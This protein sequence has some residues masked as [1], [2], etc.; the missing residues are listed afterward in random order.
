[1]GVLAN[2]VVNVLPYI[3]FI[4]FVVGVIY[5][6]AVWWSRPSPIPIAVFPG[7]RSVG[8]AI[9]RVLSD[10]IFF[11]SL[12]QFQGN[13]ILWLGAWLF[14]ISF[15][16]ILLRHLR[17]FLG[18]EAVPGWVAAVQGIGIA[19]ALVISIPLL[20]L[21]LRRI[22]HADI[23]WISTPADYFVLLLILSVVLSGL[24][25][26]YFARPFVI[27]VK[28]VI[29]SLMALKPVDLSTVTLNTAFLVHFF[30]VQVLAMYIPFS[31]VMH[32]G[33]IFFSPTRTHHFGGEAHTKQ[34]EE[35]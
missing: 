11:R 1:M 17:Y 29:R 14:H 7:Q 8:S 32:F 22:V 9:V 3:T 16:L 21:L 12:L 13:R 18:A 5:R 2:F 20:Y 19:A 6:I 26:K 35:A 15:G 25:A 23:K 33:G 34:L 27:D 10:V 28:Y 24:Y 31:K 30:L 4:V